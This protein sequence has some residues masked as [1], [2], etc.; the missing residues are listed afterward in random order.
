VQ[1]QVGSVTEWRDKA[2]KPKTSATRRSSCP[3]ISVR[4]SLLPVLRWRRHTTSLRG[5]LV[6]DND[7]KHPA[8]LAKEAATIDL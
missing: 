2:R 7:Y 5:S 6:Y 1:R 3:I 8:I 4:R